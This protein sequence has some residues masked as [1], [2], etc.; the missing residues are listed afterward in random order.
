MSVAV[1]DFYPNLGTSLPGGNSLNFAVQTAKLGMRASFVGALGSDD[2]GKRI[3]KI[4]QNRNIDSSRLHFAQG[5]TASNILRIRE[6]GERYSLPEDWHG[7]AYQDF[8]ISDKD[9]AFINGHQALMITAYD[10]NFDSFLNKKNPSSYATVDFLDSPKIEFLEQTAPYLSALFF[11]APPE[12]GQE[13]LPLSEKYAALF[14]HTSDAL[15]SSVYYKGKKYTQ[16]AIPV[17]IVIDTTGCGDTFHSSFT[18]AYLR[19]NTL[20]ECLEFAAKQASFRL[21]H[22]GG[23]ELNNG[24]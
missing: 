17:E 19:G 4:L 3:K 14:I 20:P 9:W 16:K 12:F 8:R 21:A 11:N 13:I 10:P 18:V 23:I 22:F 5:P 2:M 24:E 6:D 15:G 1:N 7:N